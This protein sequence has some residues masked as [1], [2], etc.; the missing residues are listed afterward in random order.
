MLDLRARCGL[1]L[2]A[3]VTIA[4][5]G[6]GKAE[7]FFWLNWPGSGAGS[8]GTLLAGGNNTSPTSGNSETISTTV[9]TT[10]GLA[11][12]TDGSGGIV[13][14]TGDPSG[15]Q[16]PEPTTLVIGLVGLGSWVLVRRFCQK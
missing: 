13:S 16:V 2:G 6:G 10:G 14:V 9:T 12:T 3:T 7:A 15:S 4:L 1:F 11:G 5:F 8:T